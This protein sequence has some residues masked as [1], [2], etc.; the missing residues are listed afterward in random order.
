MTFSECVLECLKDK[1]LVSQF[2]RLNG[3]NL[4]LRGGNL[5]VG[6]DMATGRLWL[7][8]LKFFGFVKEC[9]WDRL[10][11]EDKSGA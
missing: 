8:T 3:T 10:P 7:D 5:A 6:I 1:E 11:T 9:V 4:S 2:D